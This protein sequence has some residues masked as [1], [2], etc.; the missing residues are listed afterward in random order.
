M[1]KEEK[2]RL[3]DL[4]EERDIARA[5]S[6]PNSPKPEPLP[7]IGRGSGWAVDVGSETICEEYQIEA[8][9]YKLRGNEVRDLRPLYLTEREALIA[10]HYELCWKYGKNLAKLLKLIKE[11][12]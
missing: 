11:K 6:W 7:I 4:K 2:Q 3:T 12:E 10:L 8:K 1:T 9:N 5:F